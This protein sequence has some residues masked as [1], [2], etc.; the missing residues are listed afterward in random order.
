MQKRHKPF[1]TK[2][3]KQKA[4][5]R[6]RRGW[7]TKRQRGTDTW[8][9][10]E[11]EPRRLHAGVFLG[12]LQWHGIDGQVRRIRV[13]QGVRANSI[14]IDGM[15]RDIGFDALFRKMRGSLSTRKVTSS[16]GSPNDLPPEGSTA[17]C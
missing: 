4:S 7:E 2:E 15:A 5:A 13:R 12:S 16:P 8:G 6:S 3:E 11:E 17:R 10:R 1:R 9:V 14:R